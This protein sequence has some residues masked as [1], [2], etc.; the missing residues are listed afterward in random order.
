MQLFNSKSVAATPAAC[1]FIL[2]T[3]VS[4]LMAT[5]SFAADAVPVVVTTVQQQKIFRQVEVTGTVT[6]PS[7]AQLSL[8]T[9]GLVAEVLA[10]E[11]DRVEAG[12]VLLRLD[13]ELAELQW[14]S[15]QAVEQQA[16]N[17]HAD[18]QRRLREAQRLAPQR[19][20]A[21]TIVFGLENEVATDKAA[22]D[23]A[24]ADAAFQR[25]LLDRH[26]LKA[27]FTGV[28]SNKLTEQGEW[29]SP[30][31]GVF[32]LVA[33][34]GLRLDF[35]VGEDYLADLNP[36]TQV[37]FTLSAVP[38]RQFSGRVSAIV[39][40]ANPGAR[41]FLLRVVATEENVPLIPGMSVRAVLQIATHDQGLVVPRDATLR[42]P[43]GRIIVW[44]VE[45]RDGA[46]I[47]RENPVQTGQTFDGQIE[48][49]EGLSAGAQVVIEG[50]E[51][52][53]NGQ[54]VRI[55]P[56]QVEIDR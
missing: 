10:E 33:T 45:K 30:G 35:A 53:Q 31:Q 6:S 2:T 42:F 47:S 51:T 22:L 11:G 54:R 19:S 8:A 41:T 28:I 24:H 50:N 49:R 29:V 46:L 55:G 37:Q 36:D 34:D 32:E 23:Q 56:G 38:G 21:E 7:A 43:D 25:A 26:Q 15:A 27:P 5:G 52:L 3:L 39:P 1:A 4:L 18:A 14:Q 20:I 40:V 12:A 9:S 13:P 44:T 17:A 16:Q 48:I